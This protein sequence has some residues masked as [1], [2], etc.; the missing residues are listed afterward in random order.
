MAEEIKNPSETVPGGRYEVN[1][2]IV[3]SEGNP[4]AQTGTDENENQKTD[5]KETKNKKG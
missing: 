2:K 3:N 4:V 1:G 5:P